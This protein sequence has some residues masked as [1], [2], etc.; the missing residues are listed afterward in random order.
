MLGAC[1][2]LSIKST[3][4]SLEGNSK[5]MG[6]KKANTGMT[7]LQEMFWPAPGPGTDNLHQA[8]QKSDNCGLLRSLIRSPSLAMTPRSSKI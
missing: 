2:Y 6:P 8:G 4:L 3:H 7:I 5:K 1:R